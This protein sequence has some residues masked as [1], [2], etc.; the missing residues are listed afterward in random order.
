MNRKRLKY[1]FPSNRRAQER[2]MQE[3]LQSLKELA[4]RKELGN[5]TRAAERA[6]EAWGWPWDTLVADVRYAFRRMR[7]DPGFTAVAVITLALGVG[8]NSAVFSFADAI[9]LRPLPVP[10]ASEV[11]RISDATPGDP[12]RG[13]SYPA[14]QDLRAASRSYSGLIAYRLSTAGVGI[15]PT[16][17]PRLRQIM[18]VSDQFFE[19]CG[20]NLP[21]GRVF[22]PQEANVPGRDPVAVLGHDFWMAGYRGDPSVIGQAL[23]LNGIEFT[24]VGVAPESFPGPERFFPPSVFVPLS[25]WG[26][27]EG[28]NEQVLGDRARHELTL[29]GRLRTGISRE[30]AQLELNVLG[31]NLQRAYPKTDSERRL[32]IWTP[33]Q[34]VLAKEPGRVAMVALLMGLSGIVLLLACTNVA[35]LALARARAR[36]REIAIRLSIGAGTMRLLRQLMTENLA[37][38]LIGGVVGLAF[39]Y[40]GV[41]FLSTIRIPSDPPFVVD[42]RMDARVLMFSF[43]VALVSCLLFGFAPALQARRVQLATA[44][45]TGGEAGGSR[46]RRAIGRNFL[47]VGQIA[48]AMVLLLAAGALLAGFRK[49]LTANPGFQTDHLIAVDLN[50][51][52]RRY[53]SDRTRKFYDQ[54]VREVRTLPGV[55]SVTLA[56]SVP[57]S[58]DQSRV[59]LIP[60]GFEPLKSRESITEMGGAVDEDF[61]RTLK[62]PI[63]HGREFNTG[64]RATSQPVAIVNE[65]FVEKYWPHQN[66]LGK[67][68]RLDGLAG[69]IAE[70]VGVAKTVHYL[71]PW[72]PPQPYVYLAY[73]QSLRPGMSLI[74]ESRGDPAALGASLRSVIRKLDADL[75]VPNLRTVASNGRSTLG[76]WLVIVQVITMMG[77]LGLILALVGLYGLISYGVSRRTA[78]IGIRMAVG[79]SRGNVLRLVLGQAM[80][81][82]AA[83]ITI[84]TALTVLA[85]PALSAA[86]G[87]AGAMSAGTYVAIPAALFVVSVAACYVP[88]RRAAL[89]DPMRALHYE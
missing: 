75:P 7:K 37:L 43:L 65:E 13:L 34:A 45:K 59:T 81:L 47:V 21:L 6:R 46:T 60:E 9:L 10:R 44:L 32:M 63:L 66:A 74:A 15:S 17:A 64:D 31:D 39:G 79:A 52:I 73:Q 23:R 88:A 62:I 19:T 51:S 70:V 80:I 14:Y 78:E 72:E 1:L 42:L 4:E 76:S 71:L 83:G 3:E 49:M 5:L 24:I 25:M 77:L 84:G 85:T 48:L 27:L 26:R 12:L 38:A 55:A 16:E 87:G 56:E 57:L 22:L 40:G 58:L 8:A 30:S 86:F 89:L 54:L 68:L 11:V 20:V 28:G 35:N 53:S 18:L 29:L 82:A 61:F 41:L 2:D 50:T 67:R 33:L 69:P 36:S